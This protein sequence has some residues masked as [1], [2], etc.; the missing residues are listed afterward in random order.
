MKNKVMNKGEKL[1][2]ST[3]EL[4]SRTAENLETIYQSEYDP[5]F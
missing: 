4:I 3:T 2:T 1:N 5:L